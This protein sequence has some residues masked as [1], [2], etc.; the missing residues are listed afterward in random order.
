[1][2]LLIVGAV[3][4]SLGL[5]CGTVLVGV[6][7]GLVAAEPNQVLALLFPVFT[8]IGF[9]LCM[10]GGRNAHIHLISKVA[11]GLLL[12]LALCSAVFIVLSAA[13]IRSVTSTGSLWYVMVVAG[14]IGTFGA[15]TLSKVKSND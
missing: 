8:V 10:V 11:T 14:V 13:S 7:L 4:V 1:M 2:L 9:I 12:I 3:L 15:A 5:L 6:P